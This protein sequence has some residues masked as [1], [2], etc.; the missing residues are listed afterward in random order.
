MTYQTTRR[1]IPEHTLVL[2]M[3]TA[4]RASN[5]TLTLFSVSWPRF[6]RAIDAD[7]ERSHCACADREAP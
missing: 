1:Y 7:I 2:F 3:V 6:N 4:V 5:P